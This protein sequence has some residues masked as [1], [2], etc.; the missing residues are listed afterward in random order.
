MAGSGLGRTFLPEFNEGALTINVVTK[1]GTSLV[2]SDRLGQRVERAL[3]SHPE[4]V[5]T[6]RRTGRA[7]LDEHA[8]DVNAAEIDVM[9]DLSRGE[10]DKAAFLDALRADLATIGG[11]VITVG[12]PLSH[13]IDHLLSGTRSAIALKVFGDDL[14]VLRQ[15]ATKVEAV[16]KTVPGAVDVSIEQQ[17]DIPSFEVHADRAALARYGLGAGALGEEVERALVGETVGVVLEGQRP[18]DL[19]V[20]L[21]DDA[22]GRPDLLGALL[23]DTPAGPRVPLGTLAEIR[24][25]TSPNT[26][27]REGGA[28]KMVVQANVAGRDLSVVVD[29]LRARIDAEVPR[30]PGVYVVY[31]GQFESAAEA[32]RTI[33]GLSVGVVVA[34]F[35]LLTTAFGSA[36]NALLMLV[37]LPL[38]L[39]G[40]VAALWLTSGTLSTPALVGFVTLFGV[41]TRNGILMVTHYEHLVREEG[42]TLDDA[43]RRGSTERLIPVLMT[44]LSAGLALVPLVLAGD[45]PGNEIQ[46]PMGVVLLGGLLSSTALNMVVVPLVLAGD[47]PGNEI[48]AP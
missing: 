41:A 47:A 24:R 31:G 36:R 45:A 4:V 9:L 21:A 5:S 38:S 39:I 13:R 42:L 33:G 11:A 26:V 28:R 7:E 32:A 40:G 18:V 2:A 44:A 20:R 15:V 27:V 46:A 16:A 23:I 25:A 10:H 17:I 43:V 8:Q 3:L 22:Q 14:D 12:Q 35:L 19:V 6:S 30:P 29:E 37:N 1:P 34:V 48:Q